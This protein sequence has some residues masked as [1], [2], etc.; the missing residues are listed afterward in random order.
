MEIIL[1]PIYGNQETLDIQINKP[2]LI[3]KDQSEEK[4]AVESGWTIYKNSWFLS[5]M[6]RLNLSFLTK[7]P[8][9]IKHHTVEYIN[10]FDCSTEYL[11]LYQYF[12]KIKNFPEL[13]DLSSDLE[14][15]SVLTIRKNSRLVGFSKF[16]KYSN[17]I[18]S[19]YTIIDYAEP[20]LSLGR[21]IIEFE[22]F[23]AKQLGFDYLY[24]GCGYGQGGKYKST[25]KGFEWWNGSEW[26]SNKELYNT[27]CEKDSTITNLT[28]L[29]EVFNATP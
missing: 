1:Y 12:L 14:R 26:S 16:I 18:E 27:L 4:Q 7:P 23:T 3:L 24:I 9:Q 13:Y 25:L 21:K 5:R 20:K 29:N 15:A 19:Q 11:D 2:K 22:M 6:T 8:K 10:Y 28:Q 17:A